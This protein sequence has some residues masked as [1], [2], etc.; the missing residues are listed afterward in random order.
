M[1]HLERSQQGLWWKVPHSCCEAWQWISDSL[2][3]LQR[4][5]KPG[6]NRW[7][8]EFSLFSENTGGKIALI[9]LVATHKRYSDSPT[10]QGSKTLATVEK[11]AGS[12]VSWPQYDWVTLGRAQTCG[13]MH[14]SPRIY[15]T[16]G[17]LPR[18][19]AVWPYEKYRASSKL[20]LTL[21]GIKN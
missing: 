7:K 17:F 3:E 9:S 4:H 8:D 13:I 18:R 19:P 20:S 12:G 1:L 21:K 10:R 11:I 6:Q 5:G 15:W 16:G 14:D 2:C